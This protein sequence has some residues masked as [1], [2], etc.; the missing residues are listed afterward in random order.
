MLFDPAKLLIHIFKQKNPSYLLL[1]PI[2]YPTFILMFCRTSES[3]ERTYDHSAY[4]H[5]ERGGSSNSFDRQRHYDSDYYRDPRD[6]TLSGGGSGTANSSS[7]NTAGSSLGVTGGSGAIGSCTGAAGGSNVNTASLAGE[8]SASSG[9]SYFR[10]QS[11]SPSRF[12][13]AETRYETRSRDSYTLASMVHWD[14]NREDRG[15]RDRTHRHSR[16][17]SPHTSQSHNVS[18]QR[19]TN[20]GGRKLR[21]PNGSGTRS[22][23]SSSDSVSSSTSSSSS[24]S[25]SVTTF[26]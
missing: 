26:N 25:R 23:S 14:V 24:S 2:S 13:T 1:C 9:S 10:S 7:V 19:S 6:R 17:R 3:R 22:R 15:R 11:G 21:S 4:G 20:K 18:P 16:S 12:E 8:G 5:L